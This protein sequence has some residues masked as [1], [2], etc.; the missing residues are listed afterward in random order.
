[1]ARPGAQGTGHLVDYAWSHPLT[2]MLQ[3]AF[4]KG[5]LAAAM[6]RVGGFGDGRFARCQ[7]ATAP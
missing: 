2:L 5:K 3:A 7:G 6:G 1:M 4:G